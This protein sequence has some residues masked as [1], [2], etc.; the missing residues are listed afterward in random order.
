MKKNPD[1][2]R[3]YHNYR[4]MFKHQVVPMSHHNPQAIQ[5]INSLRGFMIELDQPC[6]D[7]IDFIN[8][9]YHPFY[10]DLDGVS[11]GGDN[12][13]YGFPG[14]VLPKWQSFDEVPEL[15]ALP[16][17][18]K[19]VLMKHWKNNK[20][21]KFH[22]QTQFIF[23]EL[24]DTKDNIP[25]LAHVDMKESVN[26]FEE[27]CLG[28]K[29]CIAFAPINPDGMLLQVWT[30]GKS[31]KYCNV[32]EVMADEERIKKQGSQTWTICALYSPWCDDCYSWRY[33]SCR[34][35]LFWKEVAMPQQSSWQRFSSRIIVFIS[36]FAALT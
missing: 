10:E 7:A 26:K 28:I 29:S 1:H 32:A 22:Y 20:H 11:N 34:R 2:K 19:P 5:L 27:D 15:E 35:F 16:S 18:F 25:Q 12:I 13:R 8:G 4:E 17:K 3:L 36:F 9:N 6:L 24:G 30:E 14:N 31:T 23:S 21:I 33:S